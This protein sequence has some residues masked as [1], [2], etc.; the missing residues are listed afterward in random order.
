[1]VNYT[2]SP[3]NKNKTI[4]QKLLEIEKYLSENTLDTTLIYTGSINFVKT[5]NNTQTLN[6][7]ISINAFNHIP[8]INE[9]FL[10]FLVDTNTNISYLAQCK[11]TEISNNKVV[12]I[13]VSYFRQLTIIEQVVNDLYLHNILI[14]NE[15]HYAITL[16]IINNS[17][18]LF[19]YDTLTQYLKNI[20]GEQTNFHFSANGRAWYS[21]QSKSVEIISIYGV[22]N[23]IIAEYC[24]KEETTD[25]ALYDLTLTKDEATHV[26]D[27]I[28]QIN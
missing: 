14:I 15:A 6:V 18:E 19:T 2:I 25:F 11:I 21:S 7:D 13:I 10:G 24:R 23:Y 26:Y 4:L 16:S 3:I 17:N 1:M 9:I 27:C 20:Q 12:K 28:S 8:A 5:A 22:G